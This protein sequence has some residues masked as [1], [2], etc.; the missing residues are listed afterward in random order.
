MSPGQAIGWPGPLAPL[1]PSKDKAVIATAL[2]GHSADDFGTKLDEIQG[3]TTL[4]DCVALVVFDNASLV[5][6][7]RQRHVLFEYLPPADSRR[8]CPALPWH[9]YDAMRIDS[10]DRK[11]RPNVVV[12]LTYE[13]IEFCDRWNDRIER[14]TAGGS[15]IRNG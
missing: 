4:H 7:M 1:R 15:A 5:P 13:S 12:P 3:L 11:W 2:L 14:E 10:L 6:A 9:L 8:R